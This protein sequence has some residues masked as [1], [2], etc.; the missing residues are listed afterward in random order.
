MKFYKEIIDDLN[1]PSKFILRQLWDIDNAAQGQ[2]QKF[3]SDLMGLWCSAYQILESLRVTF[4]DGNE[5]KVAHYINQPWA[6]SLLKGKQAL[7]LIP[8]QFMNDPTE[9][10]LLSGIL[11]RRADNQYANN[12]E[13]EDYCF[14]KSFSFNFDS[15]NQFRLYGKSNNVE[16][17]GLSLVFKQDYFLQ[18]PK[19]Y[20]FDE[21]SSLSN[22]QSLQ[23][24]LPANPN[25]LES[26]QDQVAGKNMD[27]EIPKVG[28]LPLYRCI[29][30]E[31]ESLC[32]A[33]SDKWI[34]GLAHTDQ[35]SFM[36][37]TERTA[38]DYQTYLSSIEC[39]KTKIKEL[40]EGL[41]SGYQ[42]VM[43]SLQPL[44]EEEKRSEKVMTSVQ[45][46]S[47]E[48]RSQILKVVD[49]I[50]LPLSF[51]I[52]HY[53]FKE[54]QECRCFYVSPLS[55]PVVQTEE[56]KEHVFINM[57]NIVD[58]LQE[59]YL[60]VKAADS[61]VYIEKVIQDHFKGKDKPRVRI[62]ANPFK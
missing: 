47:E 26:S 28:K 59:I 21:I 13:Q 15:L 50:L 9:G 2:D 62:S 10:R 41:V 32:Q 56:N 18:Q 12:R 42:T 40:L 49:D 11:N 4:D 6:V 1:I 17:S 37:G 39:K 22:A 34:I 23:S 52:K 27:K 55:A 7:R 14:I 24:V 16:A 20:K 45:P 43:T 30:L 60:G 53:A 36:L 58:Q 35:S 8:L 54:E 31:P 57:E 51:L 48:K 19:G 3:K 44:S 61:Q 29:Y 33:D 46:L 25:I 5:C 38:G